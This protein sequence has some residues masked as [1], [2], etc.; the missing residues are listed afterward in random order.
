MTGLVRKATLLSVLGVFAAGAAMAGVPDPTKSTLSGNT[1]IQVTGHIANVVDS[2]VIRLIGPIRDAG[3]NPIANSTVV[4]NFTNC[5]TPGPGGAL[6][7]ELSSTQP[8]HPGG[9]SN[10]LAKTVTAVTN[11]SGIATFRVAGSAD[12]GAGG[13]PGT[14]TPCAEVRADGILMGSLRV[15]AWDQ[16]KLGGCNAT[17]FGL[18]LG[19]AFAGGFRN[20]SDF[21]GDLATNATD[22]GL[23]LG[24]AFA[25]TATTSYAVCP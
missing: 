8:H 25:G 12:R 14:T 11:A 22:F 19:D 18:V 16:N 17:D 20:R 1:Y 24:V 3:N 21:N 2:R 15:A 23:I 9:L 13:S 4:I 5:I 6:D 7:I 10:C